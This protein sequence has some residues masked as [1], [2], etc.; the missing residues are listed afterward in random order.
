MRYFLSIPP[1]ARM[2]KY[3]ALREWKWL[4]SSLEK[5]KPA[6]L[7]DADTPADDAAGS[8][9]DA[10]ARPGI[11][12]AIAHYHQYRCVMG[13]PLNC[14][15]PLEAVEADPSVQVCGLCRFPATLPQGSHLV[16]EQ[17]TYRIGQCLGQRG[18]GRLYQG[19][20]LSSEQPVTIKEY[21][22]PQRYYNAEE[23][24]QR[25][26]AFL[27]LAGLSLSDGRIQD[28]R[29]VLPL[30]AIVP[31]GEQRVYLITSAIDSEP[32]LNQVLA[33]QGALS[34][35]QVKALLNQVLQTLSFLHQQ[36]FLLPMGQI[37]C[38]MVHGNLNLDS[39]LWV[40]RQ[41]TFVH[42]T[43]F[44]LWEQLFDPALMDLT[45]ATVAD[46]LTDLGYL[47]F[48]AL[49]GAVQDRFNKPLNPRIDKHWPENTAPTLQQFILRLVGIET[50]FETA[51]AARKALLQIPPATVCSD[52]S[53]DQE[54]APKQRSWLAKA[55][56]FLVTAAVIA[57][58]G[59]SGWLWL[60][61]RQPGLAQAAP[62]PCCLADI[63]GV[64][65]GEFDYASVTNDTWNRLVQVA[66]TKTQQTS[67][68]FSELAAAQPDL[69]LNYQ[70][71][72]SPAAAIASI[73]ANQL[74]FAIIPLVEDP[75][76]DLGAKIVAYDGLVPFVAFNS[77]QRDQ[78]LPTSLRGQIS[79]TQLQQLYTGQINN[80]H[81]I[82][83]ADL[84]VNL[85]IP[86]DAVAQEMLEYHVLGD[87]LF[88]EAHGIVQNRNVEFLPVLAMLRAT[89]RDFEGQSIG[90]LGVAPLS[91]IF[92]QCSV[93]P[94]AVKAPGRRA[95]QPLVLATGNPVTPA[96][97]LCD[98][99][100][101]YHP[102]EKLLREGIY[103]L[104]YP[105]AVVYP[106]DNSRSDIGERFADLLL[107]LEGQQFLQNFG[108][109]TAYPLPDQNGK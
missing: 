19:I 70:T 87:D 67:T 105:M 4:Q 14:R 57:V 84:P 27:N 81:Q 5:V 68:L 16:G 22:L 100:G 66:E 29:V 108:L 11:R 24:R 83:P 38:G 92:G 18:I 109:V 30:E 20:D 45:A 58:L 93:Y 76:P 13:N 85:Y 72:A 26:G 49:N 89:I 82:S 9:A 95:V 7:P 77:S 34:A 52:F 50:P 8:G 90:S 65:A 69:T 103:P 21:V 51:E 75:P 106:L 28:L 32:P 46:D 42:L 17:G 6:V 56:P 63:G 35:D 101:S 44:N 1:E 47:A 78:G 37:K 74:D 31:P 2:A 71:R 40:K 48:Y 107:T 10:I 39:L 12:P 25:Q 73:Q 53:P 33:E 43:D 60:R 62:S 97:E 64:A 23:C 94:L 96:V 86:E 54:A 99:K 59:G 61:S 88:S 102:N 98:R 3:M 80:W 104:A 91:S 55:T 41:E 15:K 36:K 79:L